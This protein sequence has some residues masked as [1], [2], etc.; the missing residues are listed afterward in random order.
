MDWQMVRMGRC[1]NNIA[2]VWQVQPPLFHANL[3]GT[4]TNSKS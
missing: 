1:M 3:L 4:Q 2:K